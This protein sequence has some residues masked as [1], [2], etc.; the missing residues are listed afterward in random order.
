MMIGPSSGTSEGV[1]NRDANE[2]PGIRAKRKVFEDLEIDNLC[3]DSCQIG[4]KRYHIT[5]LSSVNGVHGIINGGS[6]SLMS[7]QKSVSSSIA[8]VHNN[9]NG[10]SP[11][12]SD[13]F[14]SSSGSMARLEVLVVDGNW[15][16]SS[17]SGNL[18]NLSSVHNSN[19]IN[20][21]VLSDIQS[22]DNYGTGLPNYWDNVNA[23]NGNGIN[24]N[25]PEVFVPQNMQPAQAEDQENGNLSWLLDFKLDSLIEA[26]EEKCPLFGSR[27]NQNGN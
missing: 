22:L 8:Y 24:N 13:E 5:E 17:M 4:R 23:V 25:P 19:G 27:D 16:E 2:S 3:D 1:S 14:S 10:F 20:P 15:E 11:M 18:T 21:S 6:S 12:S 7:N 9:A 26:P